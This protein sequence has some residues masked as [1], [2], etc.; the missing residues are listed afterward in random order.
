ADFEAVLRHTRA[1]GLA[2]NPTFVS[3]TPWTT[4]ASFA[5]MLRAI[6]EYGL[7]GQVAPVQYGI[8]LLIPPHSRLLELPDA[9]RWLGDYDAAALSYRWRAPEPAVEALCE[10]VQSAVAGSAA[11]RSR[12]EIF[13]EVYAMAAPGGFH[14]PAA[15]PARTTVPYLNEPWFC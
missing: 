15:A 5:A 12:A 2:L 3:F 13:E 8:R 11:R 1:L 4:A 14:L 10:R 9:P 6:G 7:A